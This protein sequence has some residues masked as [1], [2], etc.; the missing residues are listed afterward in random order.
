MGKDGYA[1]RSAGTGYR[2]L[3][4]RPGSTDAVGD[5]RMPPAAGKRMSHVERCHFC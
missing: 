4:D 2:M 1:C 3:D 5:F